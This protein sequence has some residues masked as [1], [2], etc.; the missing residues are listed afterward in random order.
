MRSCSPFQAMVSTPPRVCTRTGESS[1]PRR[2][3]AATAAQAPV[4]QASVSPAP[5][6]CTRRRMLLRSTICMK[7][8]LTRRAK[9]G[10]VSISGPT[11]ATGAVSTLSTTCTACGLEMATADRATVRGRPAGTSSSS[12]QRVSWPSL[13]EARPAVSKGR[14]AG[15]K[16][17]LPM[18]TVTWPLANRRGSITP[19][20]STRR[21]MPQEFSPLA[22]PAATQFSRKAKWGGPILPKEVFLRKRSLS[23]WRAKAL[24]IAWLPP[25]RSCIA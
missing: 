16:R 11:M 4:P 8:A 2:M 10:W 23:N 6:S 9:R 15:S 13:R 24:L 14:A 1:R 3:P 20:F 12:S 17:V 5:R 22:A 21:A 7:P 25:P 18:S 19:F